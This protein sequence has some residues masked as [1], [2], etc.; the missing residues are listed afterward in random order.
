MIRKIKA[1]YRWYL[2]S[3]SLDKYANDSLNISPW[4]QGYLSFVI[5]SWWWRE[6]NKV[7]EECSTTFPS[8]KEGL[9]LRW[10]PQP[11]WTPSQYWL[12]RYYR[13][14]TLDRDILSSVYTLWKKK[15]F[16]NVLYIKYDVYKIL[17]A[18]DQ[19]SNGN[20]SVS[21]HLILSCSEPLIAI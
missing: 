16:Y 5:V 20:H 6:I 21:V 14:H 8:I 4:M 11:S 13:I 15:T 7:Q 17:V 10:S 19:F 12:C 9:L 2:F 18:I 1:I 3:H